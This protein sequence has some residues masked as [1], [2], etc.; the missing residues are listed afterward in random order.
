VNL[1]NN[2]LNLSRYFVLLLVILITP[3]AIAA[4]WPDTSL[5]ES[6]INADIQQPFPLAVV[7]QLEEDLARVAISATIPVEFDQL[8][9][10]Y[11]DDSNW[12]HG[13]IANI[14]VKACYKKGDLVRI[15]YDNNDAYQELSSA[16]RFDYR[17]EGQSLD[18]N[19]L[20][21]SLVAESGPLGSKD[22]RLRI[23]AQA[24]TDNQ[25]NIR[26][27]YQSRYG[28]VARSALFIYLKTLGSGK[29]GFS[30]EPN[31]QPVKGIRGILERNA[32]RY[33]L[34]LCAYFANRNPLKTLQDT[35]KNWHDYAR[36]FNKELQEIDWID[37]QKLKLQEYQDQ[38]KLQQYQGELWLNKDW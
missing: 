10:F 4:T 29:I 1:L 28:F 16:F 8:R 34:A 13:F 38:Q 12:C 35:L 9:A 27:V 14:Y 36:V 37:Y 24:T 22:Y 21:I 20:L 6:L 33:L 26:L 25:S 3:D 17:I 32:M 5:S 11:R 2:T 7:S 30:H 19:E 15:F 18:A 23:E 31:G